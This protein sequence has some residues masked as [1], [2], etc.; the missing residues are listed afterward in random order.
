M[1]SVEAC[2]RG[3]ADA[4]AV[5]GAAAAGGDGEGD[6]NQRHHQRHE[7]KRDLAGQRHRR[8][9]AARAL[10]VAQP[11]EHR[12]AAR[13]VPILGVAVLVTLAR[14]VAPLLPSVGEEIYV[15]LTGEGITPTGLDCRY[16]TETLQDCRGFLA[17]GVDGARLDVTVQV[18]RTEGPHPLVVQVHGYAGSKTSSGDIAAR[19]IGERAPSGGAVEC[20][21]LT[22]PTAAT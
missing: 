5:H 10:A 6:R 20:L 8:L 21:L 14:V 13:L 16:S 19:L 11:L 18:P 3:N 15:G 4:D 2:T 22:L 12:V 1:S 9:L 17:S 7:R